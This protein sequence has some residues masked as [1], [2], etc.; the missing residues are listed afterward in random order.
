MRFR[1]I[2][3]GLEIM[4][5]DGIEGSKWIEIMRGKNFQALV[6]MGKIRQRLGGHGDVYE[7]WIEWK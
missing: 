2:R 3:E 6:I 1:D 7:S 4:T 5:W